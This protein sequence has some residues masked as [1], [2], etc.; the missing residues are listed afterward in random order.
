MEPVE[1]TFLGSGDAFGSGGRFQACVHVRAGP[2][3]CLIDC[4]ASSLVA[5]KRFGVDPSAV[6]VVLLSHLHGDHFGGLPFL[7]LDGQFSR[8]ART[9]HVAGPPGV[10]ARVR[11]AMEVLFPG[12][13]RVTRAFA[14]EFLELP[15]RRETRVQALAV[16]AYPVVHASGA[17]AFAL[18]VAAGG[19]VIGYSGDTEWTDSLVEAARGA[20]VFVCEA[21][22][23]EKRVKYHLDWRTVMEHRHRLECRRLILTHMSEDMLR[24]LPLDGVECAEDGLMVTL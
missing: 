1:L 9:L 19:K 17:P 14:L 23:F 10:E 11:E 3:R 24:R 13:S 20:D 6:E 15:E 21:Y 16:T 5:M 18:R 7:V 8:R 4:G 22:S 2:T 12:S